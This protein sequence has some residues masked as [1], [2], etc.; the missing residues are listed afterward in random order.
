MTKTAT[1]IKT[2]FAP[3]VKP[4]TVDVDEK[5]VFAIMLTPHNLF[6]GEIC[7]LK[8]GEY[9]EEVISVFENARV[10]IKK[11]D[12]VLGIV[13]EHAKDKK[14]CIVVY[15]DTPLLKRETISQALSFTATYNHKV[16]QLPRGWVF[17]IAHVKKGGDV[18][19]ITMPNL[20]ED[21][22][23]IAYNHSQVANIS[24]F[25]RGRINEKHLSNGV[26]IT[27]PYSV[28][29]D[30]KVTIGAGTKIGPGVVIRGETSI[31][32]NCRITNF[33][34]I[35]KSK[36][37]DGTK[38]AHMSYVG[39]AE[40]GKNCNIGCGVVFCNYDGKQKHPTIVG[41]N[42]FIGSNSNL[43]APISIGDCAF[44]GAGSTITHD[45][46]GAALALARARQAVK[47]NW[48]NNDEL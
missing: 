14:Y 28:Y 30:A 17:E 25:M 46:P 21:D 18:K 38:I 23:M 45:V 29:I 9:V 36:I 19:T 5:D 47:E 6:A 39:D 32:K 20:D 24:T 2:G 15:A 41:D 26:Y 37:G 12:D 43:V 31:G 40:I 11:G 48:R 33:V 27:D 44:I 13:K 42:V 4:R 34:D 16:V 8:V 22:F 1:Q 3:Q 35:K 10:E 7:G